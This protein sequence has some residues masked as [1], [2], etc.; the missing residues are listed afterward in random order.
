MKKIFFFT[1]IFLFFYGLTQ[2]HMT[3]VLKN[4]PPAPPFT[5]VWVYPNDHTPADGDGNSGIV[6]YHVAAAVTAPTG[7]THITKLVVAV[8]NYT[9][10]SDLRLCLYEV[11]STTALG[12]VTVNNPGTSTGFLR[13]EGVVDISI[14]AGHSYYIV[15]SASAGVALK[16]TGSF[17]GKYTNDAY[18]AT[19]DTLGTLYDDT[20]YQYD[21]GAYFE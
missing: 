13:L 11:G 6:G 21:L 15:A 10:A 20:G 14:T 17:T 7:A 5:P 8:N 3:T 18:S 9:T 19:C 16:Y 1:F 12:G 4:P 2:A